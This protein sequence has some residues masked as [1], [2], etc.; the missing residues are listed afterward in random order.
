MINVDLN[1][2]YRLIFNKSNEK[3]EN[4]TK[5]E[6]KH[7]Q[8]NNLVASDIRRETFDGDQYVVYPVVMLKHTVVNGSLVELDDLI[9]QSWNG[10]PV[11]VNHPTIKGNDVSANHPEVLAKFEVGRI[12][13]ASLD[14]DKLKAEVWIDVNKANSKFPDLL[15]QMEKSDMEVSTG[16]FALDI[17]NEGTFDNKTHKNQHKDIKP[18]H[19]ALLPDDI[20]ACSFEDGCGIR[21]N[22]LQIFFNKA[23]DKIKGNEDKEVISLVENSLKALQADIETI[24]KEGKNMTEKTKSDDVKNNC[25]GLTQEEKEDLAFFRNQVKTQKANLVTQAAKKLG[26]EKETLESWS[27]EQL[28]TVVNSKV[29]NAEE[30]TEETKETENKSQS[31]DKDYSGRANATKKTENDKDYSDMKPFSLTDLVKKKDAK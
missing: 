3:V 1:K 21:A 7:D 8:V 4:K 5:L 16:Y 20:G 19:L 29:E 23:I 15:V 24:L 17:P 10:V 18:D 22:A 28:S 25:Q 2:F 12:F 13:N 14:G 26:V 6:L 30:E 9:S 31:K 11:T 27:L